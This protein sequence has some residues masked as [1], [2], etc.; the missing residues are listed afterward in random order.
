MKNTRKDYHFAI[1]I[2]VV[3]K[4][5]QI[6]DTKEFPFI[7]EGTT[8]AQARTKALNYGQAILRDYDKQNIRAFMR[9]CKND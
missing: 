7:A 8:Y 4:T 6:T 1:Q 5:R 3:N 2:I 9:V